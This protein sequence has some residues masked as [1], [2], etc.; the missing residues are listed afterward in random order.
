LSVMNDLK[1]WTYS[2]CVD[3]ACK[4]KDQINAIK[5]MLFQLSSMGDFRAGCS[6]K[7]NILKLMIK[8]K[9]PYLI[10]FSKRLSQLL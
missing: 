3:I 1:Y 2:A 9:N 8:S 6:V 10:L 4:E 7:R 5:K